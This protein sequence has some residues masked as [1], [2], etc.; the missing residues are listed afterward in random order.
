MVPA[1]LAHELLGSTFK[2]QYCK[3]PIKIM[4]EKGESGKNPSTKK[5]NQN[6]NQNMGHYLIP[7]HPGHIIELLA[8]R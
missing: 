3:I 6:Q 1:I 4:K 7:V 5:K 8:C 2:L